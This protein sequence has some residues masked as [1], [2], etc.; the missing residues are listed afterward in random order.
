MSV[1]EGVVRARTGAP[2]ISASVDGARADSALRPRRSPRLIAAGVLC[3]CLGAL[4]GALVWQQASSSH[5]VVVVNSSVA[6]GETVR[7]SDLAVVEL[8]T[9]AGVKTIPADRLT[10]LVGKQALVDL[11]AGSLV[12]EGSIGTP[13][14]PAGTAE[15]GLKLSAGRLP[16]SPMPAGTKVVLIEVPADGAAASGSGGR[17]VEGVIVSSPTLLP[18]GGTWVVDVAVAEGQATE[19]AQLSA[20]DRIVLI[21]KGGN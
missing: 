15:L 4:G 21:K 12:G 14:T 20:K 9:A 8:G 16:T 5:P 13:T 11:P 17:T 18:D 7:A 2:P 19:V 3:G 6:R 1:D 10:E